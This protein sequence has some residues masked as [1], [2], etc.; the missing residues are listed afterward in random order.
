MR[1]IDLSEQNVRAAFEKTE[2]P[3]S[4]YGR[5][6]KYLTDLDIYYH[7]KN[8]DSPRMPTRIFDRA[9]NMVN[10][11]IAA[12][13]SGNSE[14]L[15]DSLARNFCDSADPIIQHDY[16]KFI[17]EY[18]HRNRLFEFKDIIKEYTGINVDKE[19]KHFNDVSP[20]FLAKIEIALA[21]STDPFFDSMQMDKIFISTSNTKT[22]DPDTFP[23]KKLDEYIH[24]LRQLI[25]NKHLRHH[26]SVCS[27]QKFMDKKVI[28]D[29]LYSEELYKFC[30]KLIYEDNIFVT[31]K[32][33]NDVEYL[34]CLIDTVKDVY[35][36]Y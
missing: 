22:F 21:I 15:A 33:Q 28:I 23:C 1:I 14:K 35:R 32:I 9:E 2:L 4:Y 5:Y 34:R 26:C 18:C 7:Q 6:K 24:K 8:L 27:N 31:L 20:E 29:L 11:Y 3:E 13:D 12:I 25:F 17:T 16:I 36:L 19:D 30:T 10:V